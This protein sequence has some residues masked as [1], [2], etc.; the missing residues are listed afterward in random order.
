MEPKNDNHREALDRLLLLLV[1]EPKPGWEDE[2]EDLTRREVQRL[3]VPQTRL[4][5]EDD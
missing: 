3:R 1:S 2:F 5:A 4:R